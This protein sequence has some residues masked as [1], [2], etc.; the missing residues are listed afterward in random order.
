MSGLEAPLDLNATAT[1]A[2]EIK[3]TWKRPRG[4]VAYSF[5]LYMRR[6][7]GKWTKIFEDKDEQSFICENL[8][9]ATV[10]HFKCQ[11]FG[12][13]GD[14]PF[15][16]PVTCTTAA[17]A[18]A[19]AP[20]DLDVSFVGMDTITVTW[21]PP[22]RP[23]GEITGYLLYLDELGKDTFV[24]L[25]LPAE[26]TS[27]TVNHL[28]KGTTYRFQICAYSAG[29]ESPM[30]PIVVSTTKQD[31]RSRFLQKDDKPLPTV[32]GT[33]AHTIRDYPAAEPEPE[34]EPAAQS[35]V[36]GIPQPSLAKVK[37]PTYFNVRP[38]VKSTREQE[39]EAEAERKRLEQLELRR[40]L[41]EKRT[42]KARFFEATVEDSINEFQERAAAVRTRAESGQQLTQGAGEA[43]QP[44]RRN[45]MGE[46]DFIAHQLQLDD[47]ADMADI[48]ADALKALLSSKDVK[49]KKGTIRGK[50]NAVRAA[51]NN[52]TQTSKFE[53]ELLERLHQQEQH[54]SIVL[55]VTSLAGVRETHAACDKMLK[56]FENIGKKVR[57]KDIHLD[58]RFAEE[59]DER[60]PQCNGQV[61]QAF[62][63][64]HHVGGLDRI[65]TLNENGSLSRML[66]GFE[67]RSIIPCSSC[68]NAGFIP[69]TWCF[70]SKRSISKQIGKSTSSLKCTVCNENGLQRCDQC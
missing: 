51:L 7:D 10:Y 40:Q 38:P 33:K 34:P 8:D 32:E 41:A 35:H 11:S 57:V 2:G 66:V 65:T 9:P 29:G 1:S 14:G 62:I 5:R 17:G 16:E 52:L 67:D 45:S 37:L 70:G 60:L 43:G 19:D 18:P 15:C 44:E 24:E 54:R 49:S 31:A 25:D 50:K 55:Y 61:P 30:T 3:V 22:S 68:G 39:E 56:I 27:Y 48:E 42:S 63:N 59:L 58:S 28:L 12:M 23:N 21:Q 69:C 4:L 20:L 13:S 26:R 64:F 53:S 47:S 36:D 6:Q 46:M